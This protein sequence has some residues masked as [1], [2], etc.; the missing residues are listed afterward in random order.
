MSNLIPFIITVDGTAGSGKGT[1]SKRLAK[2]FDF[3][4]LD[5]GKLYRATAYIILQNGGDIHNTEHALEAVKQLNANDFSNPE[6]SQN[7]I[8]NGASIVSKIPQVRNA[9]LEYQ[10]NFPNGHTGAVVDGRDIGTII[11][12]DA[13]VKF[14]VDADVKIRA[15][16]RYK[17][18]SSTGVSFDTILNDLMARDKSDKNRVIAPLKPADGSHFVDTSHVDIATMVQQAIV[19]VSYKK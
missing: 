4:H 12:P 16:R 9:L 19:K 15:E 6:L 10:R 1:L 17:E 14:F 3:V 13:P 18:L 11:F 2:H 5:T 7:H 8:G